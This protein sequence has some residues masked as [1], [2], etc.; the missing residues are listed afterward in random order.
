MLAPVGG[1]SPASP[2]N[3]TP[4]DT[5]TPV[6]NVDVQQLQLE[7]QLQTYNQQ[8][9]IAQNAARQAEQ[10]QR[11]I[12][13]VQQQIEQ[14]QLDNAR[15]ADQQE[16]N[17][18]D[19]AAAEQLRTDNLLA[20]RQAEDIRAD[21]LAADRLAEE[22]LAADRLAADQLFDAQNPIVEPQ[23]RQPTIDFSNLNNPAAAPAPESQATNEDLIPPLAPDDS[24][25]L[26]NT[27]V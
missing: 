12:A 13:A 1:V 17:A 11:Q 22:R 24:G 4:F 20:D 5:G 3:P 2:L 6:V 26:I 19:D 23:L 7:R 27:L 9:E 15:V 18:A 21:N 16:N 10:L 8:L 14:R 25:R